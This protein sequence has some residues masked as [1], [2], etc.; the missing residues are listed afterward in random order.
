MSQSQI[1][2]EKA[3]LTTRTELE[4]TCIG[5]ETRFWE[6]EINRKDSEVRQQGFD[7]TSQ[8]RLVPKFKEDEIDDYFSHFEKTTINLNWPKST[9]PMLLQSYV[10]KPKR[11][12]HCIFFGR[13]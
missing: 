4:K 10:G 2:L 12:M 6:L 9:W 1:E 11:H 7:L 13:R 3:K 5:Q 8:I